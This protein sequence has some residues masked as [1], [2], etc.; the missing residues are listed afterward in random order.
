MTDHPVDG[1]GVTDDGAADR[2]RLGEHKWLI[3]SVCLGAVA[4][5]FV[6]WLAL[7]G[8]GAASGLIIIVVVG[9]AMIALGTRMRG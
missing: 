2:F 6:L 9:L 5:G 4:V 7:L 3:I 1:A 8:V